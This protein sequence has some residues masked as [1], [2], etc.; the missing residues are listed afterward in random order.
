MTAFAKLDH[1]SKHDLAE[2]MP[3][4]AL[5]PAS[6]QNPKKPIIMR[7]DNVAWVS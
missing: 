7:I 1:Q 5:E 6:A 4:E 2:D 3:G